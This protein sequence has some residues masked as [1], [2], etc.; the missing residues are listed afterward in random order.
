MIDFTKKKQK[1]AT[2]K[3]SIIKIYKNLV[4]GFFFNLI[5]FSTNN[6]KNIYKYKLTLYIS[7]L[8]ILARYKIIPIKEKVNKIFISGSF[9]V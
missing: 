6:G 8:T 4:L 3:T 5:T 2:H 1:N 7:E 9:L